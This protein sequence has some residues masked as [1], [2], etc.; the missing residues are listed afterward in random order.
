MTRVLAID[1]STVAVGWSLFEDGEYR[2]SNVYVPHGSDWRERVKS[3]VRW[4]TDKVYTTG[5]AVLAYEI[6]SGDR[7]NMAT[8]RKLGGVEWACWSVADHWDV[9]WL[10]VNAM[11]VK[12][13]GCHKEALPIAKDIAGRALDAK[14]A[15][16]EAD[17]IGVGLAA[18][19]LLKAEEWRAT[20]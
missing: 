6:A 19:A 3:I 18:V 16:D 10:P 20:P 2:A 8:N 15:E 7:R 1:A 5:P 17:A 9:R 13:S 11:Q 4:L 12:A 14:N